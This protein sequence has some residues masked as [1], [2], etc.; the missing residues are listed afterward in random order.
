MNVEDS[1]ACNVSDDSDDAS[2]GANS[3][4]EVSV[5]SRAAVAVPNKFEEGLKP[6]LAGMS[7]R[8][9]DML[10]IITDP[11]YMPHSIRWRSSGAFKKYMDSQNEQVKPFLYAPVCHDLCQLRCSC[12]APGG[13][14]QAWRKEAVVASASGK[15]IFV[16][17]RT[18]SHELLQ[19]LL[20]HP[21]ASCA[22]CNRL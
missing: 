3:G 14:V 16:H 13:G 8:I 19:E 11:E 20:I 1:S 12:A 10:K 7:R 2:E 5:S 9:D 22:A 18:D 17:Y 21:Q 4:V 15:D 6:L